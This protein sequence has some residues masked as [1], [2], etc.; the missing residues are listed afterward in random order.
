[1]LF[2]TVLLAGA[3][4]RARSESSADALAEVVDALDAA[5]VEEVPADAG[6]ATDAA[7]ADP[8]AAAPDAT[9]ADA[10]MAAAAV[11]ADAAAAAP[12]AFD[13]ASVPVTSVG[14]PPFPFFKAPDGLQS[15]Y[16]EPQRGIAHDGQYFLAGD[17]AVLVEGRIFRDRFAL[18]RAARPY[19]ELEF[20]RNYENAIAA[21]GGRRIDAVQYTREVVAAAGGRGAIDKHQHGAAAVPGYRHDSYLLRTPDKEYWIDVSTGAIPLHG[22]VVVLERQAMAQSLGFLDAAAMRQAIDQDGRVALHINFDTDKATLR[23]D[24]QPTIAEIGKLLADDPA[25]QL[26]IEGHTD[27][28]GEAAHNQALSTARARSVLGALVGLGVDPARLQSRGY[29]QERPV[30]DNASEAGRAANRRV[31]L[32]RR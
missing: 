22:Y 5:P 16:R 6:V 1:M 14:L 30:A 11:A 4:D 3:C 12:A 13:P 28:T 18:T 32:V 20:H 8:A 17:K 2:V 23:P 7:A 31:E 10:A 24:A 15:S 29:G 26:S 19:S 9:A 21:L 25:L 27:A